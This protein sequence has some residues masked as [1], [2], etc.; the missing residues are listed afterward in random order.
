[1]ATA[2]PWTAP[3]AEHG[4]GPVW[5]RG[6]EALLWVD[7][8]AGDVLRSADGANVS[9]HH[10]GRVAAVVRPRAD[11]GYIVALERAVALCDEDLA[12]EET[13]RFWDDPAIRFNEGGCDP[14][15]RFF[16]GST[17][18][19]AREGAASMYRVD[20]DL[21]SEVV[22]SGLTISNGLAWTADGEAAYFADTATQRID[23]L[24]F[25][26]TAGRL[27]AREPAVQ[28]PASA[29]GPDGLAIDGEGNLWVALW[30]G[31]AVHAYSPSGVLLEVVDLPV[32]RVTACTFG[33]ADYDRLFITTS[34]LGLEDP[35]PLAGAVFAADVGARGFAPFEFAG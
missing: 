24:R 9:R 2:E 31:S 4:E 10:L 23:R 1:M 7:M 25:D 22:M 34:R 14:Y 11:G 33:G 32:R 21:S 30:D 15:G 5:P 27:L 8:L 17:A 19:D 28:I 29:G 26:R 16:C 12:V 20:S 13:S 3:V 6:Q 18:Y 35:E